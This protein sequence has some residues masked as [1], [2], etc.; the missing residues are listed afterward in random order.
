M[1]SIM[2]STR[3]PPFFSPQKGAPAEAPQR[4]PA[5]A[6]P[7]GVQTAAAAGAATTWICHL[8][9]DLMVILW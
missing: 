5:G 9:G 6:L 8:D 3:D 1:I 7:P 4:R 2:I